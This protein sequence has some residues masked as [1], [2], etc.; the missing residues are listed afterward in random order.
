MAQ[1]VLEA[2]LLLLYLSAEAGITLTINRIVTLDLSHKNRIWITKTGENFVQEGRLADSAE[3]HPRIG[4]QPMVRRHQDVW[5][6]RPPDQRH[7]FHLKESGTISVTF[8]RVESGL[9][10]FFRSPTTTRIM[11]SGRR[12][13]LATRSTSSLVILATFCR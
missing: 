10:N 9:S 5:S 2:V 11:S 3:T 1:T 13:F 4:S 6:A 12:Y 8:P 7:R